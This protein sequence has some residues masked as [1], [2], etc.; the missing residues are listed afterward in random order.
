MRTQSYAR[1]SDSFRGHAHKN[2]QRDEALED[3]PYSR[4]GQFRLLNLPISHPPHC[5]AILE[6]LV[7]GDQNFLDLGRCFGQDLRQLAADEAPPKHLYGSDL[8]P[9]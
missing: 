3:W 5:P 2:A 9:D 6:R 7:P 1:L 4:I 8:H